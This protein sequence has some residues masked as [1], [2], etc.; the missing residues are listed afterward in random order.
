MAYVGGGYTKT[1]VHNVLEPA[2]FGVP[3]VIGPNYYKFKEAIELVSENACFVVNNSQKLA[4]LLEG[5][6][7]NEKKRVDSGQKAR[8]YVKNNTGATTKILNYL[9]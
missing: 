9:K 6:Y 3:I 4:V 2:T 5:F 8:N 7:L 1:G